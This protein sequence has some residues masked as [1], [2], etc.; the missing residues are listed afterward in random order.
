MGSVLETNLL[1]V[2]I[3]KEAVGAPGQTWVNTYEIDVGEGAILGEYAAAQNLADD[4]VAAEQSLHLENVHFIQCRV[5]TWAEEASGYDPE[6][7][8]DF[9]YD[10]L[11][12]RSSDSDPEPRGIV[13]WV[14]RECVTGRAGKLFY[15]GCLSEGDIVSGDTLNPI[16]QPASITAFQGYVLDMFDAMQSVI[17][18]V[19]DGGAMALISKPIFSVVVRPIFEFV[20]RGATYCK[21]KHRWFNRAS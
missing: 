12:D 4:F 8:I 19:G 16:M 20:L 13:L 6:S 5:S 7:F 1:K 10:V 3:T 21:P 9:I 14:D 15:R 17:D 11:G 2:T 18:A